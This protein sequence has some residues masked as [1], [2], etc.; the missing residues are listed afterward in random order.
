MASFFTDR[1]YAGHR[2][3]V[4]LT[5]AAIWGLLLAPEERTMGVTI[6][7]VYLHVAATVAGM[8]LLYLAGALGLIRTAG[9]APRSEP[10]VRRFWAAG[11]IMFGLGY[12]LS[13][14]A[15]H[16]AWGGIFWAEP[17][18][19]ASFGVLA[20]GMLTWAVA[21]RITERAGG[22]LLWPAALAGMITMLATAPRVIHPESP[23]QDVTPMNIK[24]TFYGLTA[25]MLL[26]GWSLVQ[27]LS[28]E[29]TTPDHQEDRTP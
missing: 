22:H 9:L 24:A 25:V 2:I 27:M 11:T 15:A 4:L 21:P 3:A 19:R 6:R 14:L 7:P 5:V 13:L 10:W 1:R 26:V 23:I 18:V 28:G 8:M 20:V 17:R 29:A 12:G 16:V